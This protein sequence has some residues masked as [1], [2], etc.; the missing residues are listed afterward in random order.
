MTYRRTLC[1]THSLT[2]VRASSCAE[3]TKNTPQ[4]N[5]LLAN[6]RGTD[7]AFTP[8]WVWS[9][10]ALVLGLC[11]ATFL[12]GRGCQ[13]VGVLLHSWL[14]PAGTSTHALHHWT[15][16]SCGT[17]HSR[18]CQLR[19][20][21]CSA[22]L[23]CSLVMKLLVCHTRPAAASAGIVAALAPPAAPVTPETPWS[24]QQRVPATAAWPTGPDGAPEPRTLQ[25]IR[26]YNVACFVHQSMECWL[27]RPL[28]GTCR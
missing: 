25:Q 27:L 16:R 14:R 1:V 5:K 3:Q 2:H 23:L 18:S 20:E 28:Q 26:I 9:A 7:T 13:P 17:H 11:W 21:G 22:R 19:M 4:K 15:F 24:A 12:A 6:S 10:P 8:L